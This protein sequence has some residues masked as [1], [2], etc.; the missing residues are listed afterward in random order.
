[1]VQMAQM[2]KEITNAQVAIGFSNVGYAKS[3]I[4]KKEHKFIVLLFGV[5]YLTKFSK[6]PELYYKTEKNSY[7]YQF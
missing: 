3:I 7:I 5:S 4:T 1:M 2:L 6:G